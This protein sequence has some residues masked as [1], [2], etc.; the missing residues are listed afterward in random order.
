MS[1]YDFEDDQPYVVIERHEDA[2]V[3]PFLVGLAIGAGVALLFAPRSGRATRREIRR[4]AMRVRDAAEQTVTDVR[5]NVV[6]SFEQARQRVETQIETARQAV[7]LK[8]RQFTRAV[9][10]GRA[11]AEE[12]RLELEQRIAQSKASYRAGAEGA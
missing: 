9:D 2:G 6:D 10:A 7:D 11:A 5:D 4:R 1:R 3:A 8:K 12:A